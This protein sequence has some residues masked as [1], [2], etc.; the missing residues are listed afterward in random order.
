MQAKAMG[1]G[2]EMETPEAR[3]ELGGRPVSEDLR[4]TGGA[5]G[6]MVGPGQGVQVIEADGTRRRLCQECWLER[7][8]K[9]R[10]ARLSPGPA[11]SQEMTAELAPGHIGLHSS[12]PDAGGQS[13]TFSLDNTE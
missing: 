10:G 1:P 13:E 11:S 5:C 2:G 6:L 9:N 12:G 8:E 3:G 7:C 4:C